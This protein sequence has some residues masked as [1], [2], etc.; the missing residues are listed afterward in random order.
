MALSASIYLM[1]PLIAIS[2]AGD[3]YGVRLPPQSP[4]TFGYVRQVNFAS[5]YYAE[6]SRVLYPK[7]TNLDPVIL[8][9]S[10]QYDI[11]DENTIKFIEDI[12]PPV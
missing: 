5:V 7:L 3:I 1:P 10:N 8:I 6:N 4:F 9:G 11:V 2:Q 12:S